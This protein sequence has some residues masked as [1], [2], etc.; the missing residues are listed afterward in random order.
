[1]VS[2]ALFI[3]L[4]L[5]TLHLFILPLSK[6]RAVIIKGL[7]GSLFFLVLLSVIASLWSPL[8]YLLAIAVSVFTYFSKYWIISGIP[9]DNIHTAFDKALLAT[10]AT[11]EKNGNKYKVDDSMTVV[12][13]SLKMNTCLVIYK[14]QANSK[15]ANLTKEV[16]QKFILNYFI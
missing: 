1:M 7:E 14:Y 8:F 12:F 16:F 11:S 4:V 3:L 2:V 13:R 15:K 9:V 10:R 6:K 5:F